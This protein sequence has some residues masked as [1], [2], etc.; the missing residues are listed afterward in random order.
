LGVGGWGE[1]GEEFLCK[2]LLARLETAKCT[3]MP[4]VKCKG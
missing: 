2:V 4:G 1:E 3:Q